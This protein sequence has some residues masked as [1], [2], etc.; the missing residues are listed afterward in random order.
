MQE[1]CDEAP[2]QTGADGKDKVTRHEQK[3]SAQQRTRFPTAAKEDGAG[4]ACDF[5]QW[6]RDYL[7]MRAQ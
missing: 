2:E 3:R 4:G 1:L 6:I 5:E 7:K